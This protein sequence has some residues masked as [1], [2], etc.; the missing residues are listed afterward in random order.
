[1]SEKPVKKVL[2][3]EDRIPRAWYNVLADLPEAPPPPLHPA[4]GEPLGPR[5][6]EPLFP[7]ALIEQEVCSDAEVP[8][9]DEIRE[10]LA[11]WRPTPLVRATALERALDTPA[12]IFYKNE[13]VSP[14]GSHKPNTAV[15]QA[16]Y[17][18]EAGTARIATETGAGQWGSALAFS[19]AQFGIGCEVF[20]VRASYDQKPYR[21]TMMETWGASCVASPSPETRTGRGF[22]ERDPETPGSLGISIAEAV[23]VAMERDDTKYALGS[24][25]NHVLLHQTVIGL[26]SAEQLASVGAEPDVVVGCVGGGSNF[27]G[28][29]LPFVRDRIAGRDLRIVAVEPT[30]CPTLTRGPYTYDFGDS[31]GLTPLVAM[32]TLGHGFIPPPIHAGGLRYHGVAPIIAQLRRD[33]LIEAIAVDQVEAFEAGVAFARSE[34]LIPAPETC[35]ALAAVVREARRSAEE[36][37]ARNILVSFSGHGLIDLAAYDAFLRGELRPHVLDQDGIENALEA[38]AELPDPPG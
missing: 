15:A 32:Y 30:S 11:I 24:V 14:P 12:R 26:E 35:H 6:L 37:R 28:V 20:M 29:A 13:S 4:S 5:D 1:M 36:G 18:R 23:E 7:M 19:A 25:L 38:V 3:G 17:N 22:L 10:K 9:P 2:L 31:A 8:I 34:G 16:Y 21:R 33:E 27:G